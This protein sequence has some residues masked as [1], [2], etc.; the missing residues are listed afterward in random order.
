MTTTNRRDLTPV[1]D[2]VDRTLDGSLERL[3]EFLRIPSISAQP[4]HAADCRRAADWL[5]AELK[6][7]GLDASV[8]ETPGHPMVVAHDRVAA[9]DAAGDGRDVPHVLFYGHY[10]VQPVDPLDLWHS[11]PFAPQLI[12]DAD[13]ARIVARGASDDKGQVMTFVEALRAL[14]AEQG[15]LPLR[16]SMVIE[17]EEESGGANLLPFLEANREELRA[18]VAL[19]CDTGMLEGGVPAITTALRGMVGEDVTI[20]CAD[21]DLHSGLYG[22]AARN[23]LELLCGILASVRDPRTGRVVLPGFY[24]GVRDPS[25]EVRAQWRAIAP[26]DADVL[27]PVGLS[28]PAGELGYTAVEQTWCRPTFEING[29]TGGYAGDGFKT[30]LPARASAKVSF[31]LV[32]GQDPARIRD[33]FRAHVRAM[34]PPDCTA[35]FESHGGSRASVVPENGPALRAALLALG[36][37]WGR[38]AVTIGSG[39]SIPVVS[40]VRQAL[41]MD[42]LLIGFA[43]EDDRIHS[44]NEKYDLVSFHRG[45]RSWVRVLDAL[46]HDGAPDGTRDTAGAA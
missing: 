15:R 38:P 43:R 41:G 40:E 42:S 28:V 7:I 37:E 44:P 9:G 12:R 19:I 31:R 32:S 39:G 16:V 21:R 25:P 14:R 35:T 2:R 45:I 30:V 23:P 27:G 20:H 17:G 4:A 6:A 10:D 24:D 34:L 26:S 8:R 29:M 1:L 36:A 46:A 13:G 33:A 3:F 5:C 18:D 22:N 11:D